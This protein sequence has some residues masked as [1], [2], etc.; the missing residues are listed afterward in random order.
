MQNIL[1]DTHI[2]IGQFNDQYYS[3]AYVSKL[4]ADIGAEYYAVS[5]TS[6]CE[7][8]Y[9]K[10]ISELT[11]LIQMDGNK[12]L[13][14]MWV[15]PNELEKNVAFLLRTAIKWR[16]IK[17]HPELHPNDWEPLGGQFTYGLNI[18]SALELPILIHTGYNKCCQCGKYRKLIEL[19]PQN[20]FILAHGRP[21]DDAI[22]LLS[23]FE[24][25]YV[26]TAFMPLDDIKKIIDSGLSHK[27]LWGTDMCI[28]HFF[29]TKLDLVK[30]YKDKLSGLK[31]IS[32]DSQYIAITSRNAMDVFNL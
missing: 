21:I 16:C 2:H 18:A 12:V 13:P 31:A 15:T 17:V 9:P 7:E 6:T 28:P 23:P 22:R 32:T 25:V 19:H 3:P 11:E 20:T 1:I 24:N 8:N 30:Y 4:M 29:D 27:I 14:I 10:V 26:D 5:S